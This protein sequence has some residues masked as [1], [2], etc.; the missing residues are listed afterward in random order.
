MR[1]ARQVEVVERQLARRVH[2]GG[3]RA[4]AM[5]RDAVPVDERLLV[6][7]RN[8]GRGH[9]EPQPPELGALAAPCGFAA[10]GAAVR[11]GRP[12]CCAEV[13][14][15]PHTIATPH[16]INDRFNMNRLPRGWIA[17]A[18]APLAPGGP[19]HSISPPKTCGLNRIPEIIR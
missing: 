12:S 7:V 8:R 15:T 2:A 19:G 13:D 10:G 9:A 11:A 1:H 5:A 6:G 18:A 3:F 14:N 16:A 17:A 4:L